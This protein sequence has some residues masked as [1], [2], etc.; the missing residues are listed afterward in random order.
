VQTLS[1]RYE[2]GKP[3]IIADFPAL[4]TAI[5]PHFGKS[6]G[7]APPAGASYRS[8]DGEAKRSDPVFF[9]LSCLTAA[10]AASGS[11][12]ALFFCIYLYFFNSN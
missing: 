2:S 9:Y 7:S 5:Q 11:G 8:H 1:I 12:G 4:A 3:V 10:L 6:F